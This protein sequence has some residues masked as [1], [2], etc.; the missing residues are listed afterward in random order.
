MSISAAEF[1]ALQLQLIELKEGKYES[2][3]REKKLLH[4][5]SASLFHQ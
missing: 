1:E 4:G 3:D 5:M 2:Q